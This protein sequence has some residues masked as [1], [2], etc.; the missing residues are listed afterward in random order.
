MKILVSSL[1]LVL[2]SSA[3]AGIAIPDTRRDQTWGNIQGTSSNIAASSFRERKNASLAYD[4]LMVEYDDKDED[5]SNS[6]EGNYIN[7]MGNVTLEIQATSEAEEF[8]DS[9]GTEKNTN[10]DIAIGAAYKVQEN[11]SVGLTSV[12]ETNE[13]ENDVS[14]LTLSGVMKLSG[15]NY[16]GVAIDQT[17]STDADRVKYTTYR[18]GYG[19][20]TENI[21]YEVF[22]GS[23]S[24][25]SN[26]TNAQAQELILG[27]LAVIRHDKWEFTTTLMIN[28]YSEDNKHNDYDSRYEYLKFRPEYMLSSD[29]FIGA[30]IVLVNLNYDSSSDIK[31]LLT[32]YQVF[33]RMMIKKNLQAYASVGMGNRDY[34]SDYKNDSDRV[35]YTLKMSYLF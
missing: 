10:S 32:Q 13:S 25:V 3:V 27:G 18:L 35:L 24:E 8:K 4:S 33:G 34:S 22:V 29:L 30:D 23:N 20:R 1:L 12:I 6:F 15:E 26:D 14:R 16:V 31:Y 17:N 5:N 9:T 19:K 21:D 28:T 11:L 2:T 7:Q